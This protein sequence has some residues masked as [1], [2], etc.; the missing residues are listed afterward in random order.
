MCAT[1]LYIPLPLCVCVC[2]SLTMQVIKPEMKAFLGELK[3]K[4]VLGVVGGSDYPKMEEQMAGE[5]CTSHTHL[6]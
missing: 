3:K 5:D 4:A 6:L 1:S 2:V